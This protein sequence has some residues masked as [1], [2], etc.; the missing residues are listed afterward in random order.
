[1]LYFKH[2]SNMRNDRAI[3]RV[4]I[5]YGL[6]GYGLYNLIIESIT[7][8]LTTES[9]LP[10]LEETYEDLADFYNGDVSKIEEMIQYMVDKKLLQIKNGIVY[11]DKIY[12]FLQASQT[13]SP[14]IK[15]LIKTHEVVSDSL[16]QSQTVSDCHS[17]NRLEEKRIDLEQEQKKES[18]TD[19]TEYL[20]Q[21]RH[22][23]ERI[24]END[25]IYFKNKNL[26]ATLL[27]WSRDIRLLATRD[28]RDIETIDKVIDWCQSSDFWRAN[29][30]SGAK[31]RDKF[32]T[33]LQQMNSNGHK[34]Q[35]GKRPFK[36]DF[37]GLTPE[38]KV[39][40]YGK[41]GKL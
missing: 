10:T 12:K 18:A 41:G 21:A 39:E 26:D 28:G 7:E 19:F 30:L 36:H 34:K 2:M 29:I 15:E 16:R 14:Q 3:K 38:Q 40:Y 17:E 11:C 13:R 4:I 22:L 6:E 9:P 23:S 1:M 32:P 27:K 33:L 35:E 5:K 20:P 24:I 31:L 37:E 8:K 25:A